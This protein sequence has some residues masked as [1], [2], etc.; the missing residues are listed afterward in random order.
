MLVVH[1]QKSGFTVDSMALTAVLYAASN[2]GDIQIGKTSHGYLIRHGIEDEGLES[3]LIDI[4]A[5]ALPSSLG[6]TRPR[7]TWSPWLG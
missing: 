6:T 4:Y 1:V 3:Y 5:R 7:M 2:T